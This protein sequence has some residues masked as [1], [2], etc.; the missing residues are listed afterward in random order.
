M[1]M[2]IL[3]TD[4]ANSRNRKVGPVPTAYVGAS[5]AECVDSCTGCPLLTTACYAHD[6]TPAMAAA[7]VQRA[8]RTAP[9][10]YSLRA[11]LS[12]RLSLARI[13]R[14]TAIGDIGRCGR[15]L[16]DSIVATIQAEGL[17]VVGYTHHWRE[18]A[19][20]DA[21]KGR[22]MASTE[23]MDQVDEAVDAGWRATTILPKDAPRVSYT[24]AGRTVVKCPAQVTN[25]RVDCNHCA[26]CDASKPGPIVGFEVHG[27]RAGSW[28]E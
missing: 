24:P 8:A 11:A 1:P 3:W 18:Q 25:N 13:V 6:S 9:E 17:R 5:K 4:G 20:A 23:R 22:L 16:A 21:W 28:E 12:R 2:N 7:S 10:R 15:E 14:L 27:N 26:L 19:V